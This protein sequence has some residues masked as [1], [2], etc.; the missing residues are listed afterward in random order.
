V[1]NNNSNSKSLII[2]TLQEVAPKIKKNDIDAIRKWLSDRN[3]T[4]Y[5]DSRPHYVYE[6]DVDCEIDKPRVRTLRNK[7][8]DD[9]ENF[10]RKIAKD[11]AVC[12]MVILSLGGEVRA[13]P[14]AKIKPTNKK[15]E[16]LIKRYS[17]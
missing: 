3:I 12:E 7:F 16:D 5:K 10:Y 15:E 17:A 4:I 2:L 1:K 8:P 11:D 6:I 13:K 9:W 14:L